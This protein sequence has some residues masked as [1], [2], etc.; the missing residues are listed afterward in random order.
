M[1][2]VDFYTVCTTNTLE[3]RPG[4]VILTA[5]RRGRDVPETL[6]HRSVQIPVPVLRTGMQLSATESQFFIDQLIATADLRFKQMMEPQ[7]DALTV[8]ASAF[9]VSSL[10]GFAATASESKRITSEKISDWFRSQ[11]TYQRIIA[12]K[13]L[14]TAEKFKDYYSALASG[15]KKYTK[16]EATNLLGTLSDIDFDHP[17]SVYIVERLEAL[18]QKDNKPLIELI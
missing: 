7:R 14:K 16:Q 8:P 15:A 18:T 12:R 11:P 5:N 6:K 9:T 13:D 10:I 2:T 1:Q 17:I 4:F 3:D